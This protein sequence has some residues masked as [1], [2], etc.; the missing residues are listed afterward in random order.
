MSLQECHQGF[1]RPF[2]SPGDLDV[3]MY[4]HLAIGVQLRSKHIPDDYP[5]IEDGKPFKDAYI[6]PDHTTDYSRSGNDRSIASGQL[7]DNYL[8]RCP[9]GA[10]EVSVHTD[11]TID[12]KITTE[13]AVWAK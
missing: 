4:Q 13:R 10:A 2:Q 1:F 6:S 3:P 7:T 9:Y 12:N 5:P 8:A 11:K